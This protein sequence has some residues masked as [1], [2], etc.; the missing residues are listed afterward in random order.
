M[1]IH[2]KTRLLVPL[3]AFGMTLAV[4]ASVNAQ[5]SGRA[6]VS[7]QINL[8][9]TPHW[10]GVPGTRVQAIRRSD[11]TDY[12]TFRYGGYYYAYNYHN[13]R[14]YRS[15]GWRGR[16]VLIDDRSV[17]SEL[18]RVP[19]DHWRN[20]PTAWEDRR[21]QGPGGTSATLRV[22]FG[23]TPRWVG[24]RG[25]R[26]EE[27]PVAERPGYDVFHYGGSYYAYNDNRWYTS[28]RESGDFTVIEDRTVPTE[29]SK[30]PRDHWRNYPTAWQNQSPN[31]TPPG[32]EKK[33]GVPPG[34]AK[35]N[36]GR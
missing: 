22:T 35:K 26:V 17:P 16:F 25:T 13:N 23:T 4:A 9:T 2:P 34:Q 19:R 20:Y 30:V 31:G 29:L 21:S 6:S 10:E 32:L 14:W 33:G 12:D 1:T 15:R 11:R 27:I 36:R 5:G 3:L 28:S 24:I 7:L 18:R 8:G